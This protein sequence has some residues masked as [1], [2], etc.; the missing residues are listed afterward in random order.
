MSPEPNAVPGQDLLAQ[1]Q[2]GGGDY[3]KIGADYLYFFKTLGRLSPAGRVLDIG[4]GLGRMAIPVLGYL[5]SP[6][7]R[8]LLASSK[9]RYVGM[10]INAEAVGWCLKNVAPL[11][12]H[13]RFEWMDVH[14]LLYNPKGKHAPSEYRFPFPDGSFDFIFLTSV[15]TH[16]RPAGVQNYLNEIERLLVPGGRVFSTFFLI[17]DA[18]KQSIQDSGDLKIFLYGL[19]IDVHTFPC[20]LDG[21]YAEDPE[22]PEKVTAFDETAARTFFSNAGL[23]IAGDIH[24]GCWCGRE[25]HVSYQDIIIARKPDP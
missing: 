21:Y 17:N 3:E 6:W 15:F 22:M 25:R 11:Y 20:R 13:S 2:I 8:R 23:S 9:P 14:N 5:K 16:M 19:K 18:A 1:H 4:C 7:H 12:K 10:D 24:Y